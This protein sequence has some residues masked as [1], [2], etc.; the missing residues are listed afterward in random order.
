MSD[1]NQ[2]QG[3]QGQGSGQ[4][5]RRGRFQRNRNQRRDRNFNRGEDGYQGGGDVAPGDVVGESA[6][7]EIPPEAA[8]ELKLFE[9]Q[10]QTVP[11][12]AALAGEYGLKELGALRKHH[13][14]R[15]TG[16]TARRA[17]PGPR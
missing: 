9:L 11:E 1:E 6:V 3:Q 13:P 7:A 17:S 2:G 5:H 14:C 4:K 12:L 16:C 8:R 15:P 10:K